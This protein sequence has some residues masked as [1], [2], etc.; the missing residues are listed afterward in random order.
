MRPIMD[1]NGDCLL[2][3]LMGPYVALLHPPVRCPQ[4]PTAMGSS[5]GDA[6]RGTGVGSIFRFVNDLEWQPAWG[7]S[8][9]SAW[10]RRAFRFRAT[11]TRLTPAHKISPQAHSHAD[12][13]RARQARPDPSDPRNF[14]SFLIERPTDPPTNQLSKQVKPPWQSPPTHTHQPNGGPLARSGVTVAAGRVAPDEDRGQHQ[15]GARRARSAP[16]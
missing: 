2:Y 12:P 1:V 11:V 4:E 3:G 5:G 8:P 7:P 15:R 16:P 9:Q 14:P 10:W 6:H 13:N